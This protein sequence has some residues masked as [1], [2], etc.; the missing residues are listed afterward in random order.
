MKKSRILPPR[1]FFACLIAGIVLHFTV[2]LPRF[3][4]LLLRLLGLVV[5]IS[6][7]VI[8]VWADRLFKIKKTTVKPFE[9]PTVLVTHGPFR[10]S[11]H[12][13]YLGMNMVLLGVA[14]FLGSLTSL[15]APLAFAITME[16]LFIR[17]EEKAMQATFGEQYRHYR[18]QVRRWI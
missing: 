11:R 2:P 6:G 14:L 12:P 15:I 17:F 8:T 7:G 18:E 10:V 3:D 9:Q 5:G 1:F 16:L 13:M 4:N